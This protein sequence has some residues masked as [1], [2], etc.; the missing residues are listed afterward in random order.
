MSQGGV[1][2]LRPQGALSHEG[3]LCIC[4]LGC[5]RGSEDAMCPPLP[6]CLAELSPAPAPTLHPRAVLS[7][8]G[9]GQ[10]QPQLQRLKAALPY[11]T[12]I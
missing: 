9:G 8:L 5:Q 6:S 2:C 3:D 7:V 10:P 12:I 11:G 4:G 1:G